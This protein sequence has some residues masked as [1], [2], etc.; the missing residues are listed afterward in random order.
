M[1]KGRHGGYHHDAVTEVNRHGINSG[2]G[3]RKNANDT[4]VAVGQSISSDKITNMRQL[5]TRRL[6]HSM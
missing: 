6:T 1:Q 5:M 2:N 4:F 3:N